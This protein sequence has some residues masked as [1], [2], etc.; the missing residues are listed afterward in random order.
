MIIAHNG[1]SNIVA[2]YVGP[3]LRVEGVRV[4][5]RTLYDQVRVSQ[6]ESDHSL[7]ELGEHFLQPQTRFRFKRQH[8]LIVAACVYCKSLIRSSR[9]IQDGLKIRTGS[10]F[11]ASVR[12][13]LVERSHFQGEP[14]VTGPVVPSVHRVGGKSL[15]VIGRAIQWVVQE[16]QAG[17]EE[18]FRSTAR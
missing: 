10:P 7:L 2:E 16:A 6:L 17:G 12:E 3:C 13:S 15:R 1:Y 8:A 14:L 9:I 4:L 11:R 18:I 5:Y